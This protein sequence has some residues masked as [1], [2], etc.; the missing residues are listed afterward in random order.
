MIPAPA[1]PPGAATS[2]ELYLLAAGVGG[3]LAAAACSALTPVA[4]SLGKRFGAAP[5]PR[6]RDVHEKPVPRWGGLAIFAAFTLSLLVSAVILHFYLG[7]P[8]ALS[9]L[10]AGGGLLLAGLILTIVGAIDDVKDLPASRQLLAQVACALLVVPFGVEVR[11]V[12]NPFSET[13]IDLR[14]LAVPITVIWLVAVANAVNWVDGI[15]GLAAGVSAIAALTLALLAA[16]SRQ[17]ALALLAGALFGSLVGFLPYNFNGA[18]I[19][20]GGGAQVV[21]FLLA[22]ISALGAFKAPV[23]VALIVPLLVLALP[24]FDTAAVIYG[25]LRAGRPI[26]A[27]DKSHLHHKLLAR[28]YTQR[29]AVLI[30]YAISFGLCLVA[31][32]AFLRG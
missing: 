30:L 4:R 6:G 8:I 19:F 27:A 32:W 10:R 23:A 18:S 26:Y 3:A 29:Q 21:G 24:L 16:W 7:R 11:F 1:P 20:M 9:T 17:P 13:A 22:A 28:G 14:W 2:P 15:D 25:R 5:A 12:T 31:F